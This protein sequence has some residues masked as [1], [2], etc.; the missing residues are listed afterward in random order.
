RLPDPSLSIILKMVSKLS[1]F[2]YKDSRKDAT[3][4]SLLVSAYSSKVDS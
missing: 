4:A 3:W 2:R 1:L